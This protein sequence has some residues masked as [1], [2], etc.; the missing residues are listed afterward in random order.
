MM[1]TNAPSNVERIDALEAAVRMLIERVTELDTALT[2]SRHRIN[3]PL[4]DQILAY[5]QHVPGMQLTPGVIATN[6]KEDNNKVGTRLRNLF[7]MGA[8][9][10]RKDDGASRVFWFEPE[11][12]VI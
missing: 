2:R 9:K 4:R 11:E 10:S 1:A 12:T 5:M 8:I 7:D 6:L 3:D